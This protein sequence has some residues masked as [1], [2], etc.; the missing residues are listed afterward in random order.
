MKMCFIMNTMM[1]LVFVCGGVSSWTP[2]KLSKSRI[3]VE[4]DSEDEICLKDCLS[5]DHQPHDGVPRFD[6]E[7]SND[8][9][10]ARSGTRSRLKLTVENSSH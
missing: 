10:W 2:I 1:C 9:F 5:L 4:S 8:S 6:I 7:I 3:T